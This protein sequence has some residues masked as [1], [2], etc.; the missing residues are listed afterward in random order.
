[1]FSK[2]YFSTKWEWEEKNTLPFNELILSW[3]GLRP[4]TG[5]WTFF[6][7]L[8]EGEW[9]PYAEWS[10]NSQRSFHSMGA[11]ARTYQ[12]LV[13]SK[14]LC[15]GFKIKVEG[16]ELSRLHRLCVCVSHLEKHV[17]LPPSS[18]PPVK[19]KVIGQ[20]QLLVPHPRHKDLC[21]PTSTTTALNYFLGGPKIDPVEFANGSRDEGFDIHGNWILNIAEAFHKSQIPCHVERLSD[22]TAVHRHLMGGR[23]VVVS[24]KGSIPGAPKPYPEGH[25]MCIVGFEENQVL[26]IDPA[27]PDNESTW[28]RYAL[29][30]FLKAWGVRKNLAYVFNV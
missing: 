24:V 21:S 15:T 17:L 4:R 14:T 29:N 7:S 13:E 9:L 28:V 20:S 5:K 2:V 1:M 26:C 12:D 8:K 3:N 30:D 10:A 22:F 16:E 18:L 11:F 25:L 27:F 19:L 23:P 6:V